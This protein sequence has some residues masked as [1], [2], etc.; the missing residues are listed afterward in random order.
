[1]AIE[2][3]LIKRIERTIPDAFVGGHKMDI[4]LVFSIFR[5]S[6]KFLCSKWTSY[7]VDRSVPYIEE[8]M[9][10]GEYNTN[11]RLQVIERMMEDEVRTVIREDEDRIT[12]E[13]KRK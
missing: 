7:K 11:R 6:H 2:R 3:T 5:V 10:D 8:P 12:K 1:M 4:K 9:Y 13:R